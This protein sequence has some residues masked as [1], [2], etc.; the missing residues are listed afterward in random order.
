[1]TERISY[2]E[3][4]KLLKA[5]KK[6]RAK[7][8]NIRFYADGHYWHSRREYERWLLLTARQ[9]AG[10]I[11]GLKRQVP[12]PLTVRDTDIG[13]YKAD[14]VYIERGQLVAEDVKAKRRRGR[15]RSVTETAEFRRTVKHIKAQYGI[16]IVII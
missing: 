9:R 16:D 11:S 5:P 12:F 1:L 2:K 6:K 4:R 14:F 13:T 8:N 7:Y 10:E 15:R 3:A